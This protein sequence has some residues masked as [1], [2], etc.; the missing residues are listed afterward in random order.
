MKRRN[1]IIV[2]LL[3]AAIA[4]AG[5]Y[6]F[7]H[8]GHD[9]PEGPVLY[10]C[11]MHPQIVQ[12]RPGDCPICG[13]RL[14]PMKKEEKAPEKKATR[15]MYRSTMNP[16]EVSDH[17]GKD[18]MGMEMVPFEM[19]DEKSAQTP[20][21]LSPV[22]VSREKREMLGI[23]FETVAKR[24]LSRE[25]RTTARIVPDETRLFKVT[26]K[27]GGWIEKLFVNQTG[28]FV[29]KGN[30]LLSIYSPELVSAEQEYLS[31]VKARAK[32]AG[33]SDSGITESLAEFERAAKERLLLYDLTEGQIERI[34]TSG[35]PE[36]AVTLYSPATG[37][38]TEKT[39]LAGQRIM[40]NDALMV[41]V[42]LS[43]VWGE[44]DIYESDLPYV[45]AG[46]PVEV[47]LSYWPG[48]LFRGRITFLNPFL[49]AETR[50]LKAR[51]E[52]PNPDLILKPQMFGDARLSY[53]IGT[54]IAVPESAVMRSGVRDYVFVE[55]KEEAIVPRE[56]KVGL[57]SGDGY[58]EIASGLSAGERVV[59]SANF[60]VDSESSLKAAFEAAAGG[61]KH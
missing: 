33:T 12:D 26:T 61:H 25:I 23:S 42:D 22:T 35:K 51:I 46:M 41:I 40:A 21:G 29:R 11:P 19:S 30:P 54:R 24:S 49:S 47:T 52:I 60:L 14:V 27:V 43:R 2:W 28:Q 58:Y 5:V 53:S 4:V 38:V 59:K 44:A 3:V 15:T 39:A 18:S 8:R 36:R 45:R 50:T 55:G 56:V 6:A 10:T 1:R 34:K 48:K 37:Y 20:Q 16:N 31:A 32:I 57:R 13:M 17:P 9:H 7:M